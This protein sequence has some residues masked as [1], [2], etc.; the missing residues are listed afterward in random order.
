MP[1]SIRKWVSLLRLYGPV[2]AATAPPTLNAFSVQSAADYVV[3]HTRQVLHATTAH[4]DYRVLLEVVA[5]AANV[6][7]NFNAVGQPHAANL[8]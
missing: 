6:G 8:P 1:A 4:Q 2:L 5:F 3:A 7:I